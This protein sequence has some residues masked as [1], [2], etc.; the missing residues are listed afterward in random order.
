MPWDERWS[1]FAF[2]NAFANGPGGDSGD[3]PPPTI[4]QGLSPLA[5]PLD[6]AKMKILFLC[7]AHNSLS[8]RLFLVLSEVHSVTVE[9]ALSELV[10]IE[11]ANLAKPD[12]I[13]CPFLTS[14]VPREIYNEYLTLI[15]HPGPPGDAGPSALDW[16]L[17]GDDGSEPDPQKLL[18]STSLSR[19]GRSHW[20][21]TVLQAVEEFDAGPVWAF[22]QFPLDI[23]A[24]DVTKSGLYRG[25]VA[26]AAVTATLAALNRIMAAAASG[27]VGV[28]HTPPPSPDYGVAETMRLQRHL[29]EASPRASSPAAEAA[30]PTLSPHLLPQPA[31]GVLSVTLRTPFLGGETRRR[32]LLQA[33]QRDFD[34]GIHTAREISRRIRCADSQPGCLTPLFGMKLYVYGGLVESDPDLVSR[35]PFGP[36]SVVACREDSAVCVATWDGRAVWITHIRRVKRKADAA[37]W[38]KVP[39]V[40]GLRALGLLDDATLSHLRV[41]RATPDFAKAPSPTFQ[42]VWVDVAHVPGGRRVAFVH[43]EFYNGAMSAAQCGHLLEALRHVVASRRTDG[44]EDAG[45][46]AGRLAA[47]VLMGGKSYFSN[48]IA[49]NVIEASAAG[50]AA[51]SWRNIN[52]IDDVV[53]FLLDDLPRRGVLTVA[54]IRGNC[55]AG[56]VALAAACDVVVAAKE[57]VLN[58][59]YRALG[60]HGSEFHS[61]SYTGRCGVAGAKRLLRGM[62]PLSAAE[63]RRVGLVDHVVP[64]MAGETVDAAVRNWVRGLLRDPGYVYAPGTWKRHPNV[65][66]SAAGLAAARA[67][68]LGEMAKDFWSARSV[69]YHVRRRDFVRKVKACRTP[70]RFAVHRRSGGMLDEEERDEFDDVGAFEQRALEAGVQERVK[71]LLAEVERKEHEASRADA[72]VP[73]QCTSKGAGL[74]D[75]RDMGPI[76]CLMDTWESGRDP[77]FS[78]IAYLAIQPEPRTSLTLQRCSGPYASIGRNVASRASFS[79]ES[80][81][82]ISYLLPDVKGKESRKLELEQLGGETTE[83]EHLDSSA[84]PNP[85]FSSGGDHGLV[86]VDDLTNQILSLRFS[87][88]KLIEICNYTSGVLSE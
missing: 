27:H 73:T 16:V 20:G 61:L 70:L 13:I 17:M 87:G 66:V 59:A 82:C 85:A 7:T 77:E 63:A 31:Y 29:A 19:D 4:P 47:V 15:I 12:L 57:A 65:D 43:F 58:P 71:R 76:N 36:G 39:A 55:A 79:A 46:A 74:A 49:L 69:R 26:R 54:A 2:A 50:P 32:P 53:Q 80:M 5:L 28:V 45:R 48:G 6:L 18:Q 51:E 67:E 14:R 60:L 72:V 56:G 34:V 8:Q 25:A 75:S 62:T 64:G 37:L 86:C 23:D 10:M 78:S 81:V 22:E 42:E 40:S 21:V 84:Q 83:E 33:A 44:E 24:P 52:R 1:P 3:R 68:E 11:A 9:Y 41:P 30:R 88:I 35:Q 38:P